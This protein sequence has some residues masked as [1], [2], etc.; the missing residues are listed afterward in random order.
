M[1][2]KILGL[3]LEVEGVAAG[4]AELNSFS[5]SIDKLGI[6]SDKTGKQLN[7]T[8]QAT[9]KTEQ[10]LEAV[11]SAATKAGDKMD[12]AGKQAKQGEQG[13]K[14]I[15]EAAKDAAAKLDGARIYAQN[16]ATRIDSL[17][18][19]IEPG[20]AS[21]SKLASGTVTLRQAFEAG[22]LSQEVY[23]KNLVNLKQHVD[24]MDK[25]TKNLGNTSNIASGMVS[26]LGFAL[27][28]IFSITG[29]ARVTDEYTRFTGQLKLA[30][31]STEEYAQAN[32]NTLAIARRAQTEV[33]STGIL[34]ARLN[35][36]LRGLNATQVEVSNIS[37]TVALSLRVSGATAT[38]SASAMLQ[39]SQAF[40]SGVL[41]GEEFN[42][43]N[44]AAPGL[45][46]TL[47]EAIN[48]PV[49][50]LREMASQGLLTSDILA[51]AFNNPKA[52]AALRQQAKEMQTLGS[53]WQVL[54][55]S[56]TQRIGR[57]DQVTGS[58]KAVAAAMLMVADNLGIVAI[59]GSAAGAG[60]A[61][62]YAPTILTGI[63]TLGAGLKALSL[64]LLGPVGLVIG[65]TAAAG[66]FIL[67]R[68]KAVPAL[69]QVIAKQKELNKAKQVDPNAKQ[70]D[71]YL[72]QKSSLQDLIKTQNELINR[73]NS[74]AGGDYQ[75]T[76][77][78]GLAKSL[79]KIDQSK[80][81]DLNQKI[82]ITS[83]MIK[84]AGIELAKLELQDPNRK[85]DPTAKRFADLTSEL[86]TVIDVTKEYQ[87]QVKSITEAANREGIAQDVL[88]A[89]L[90]VLADKYNKATGQK[91]LATEAAN[92]IANSYESIVNKSKDLVT[93]LQYEIDAGNKL[94]QGQKAVLDIR[95]LLATG[96]G[97]LS[98]SQ[99]ELLET[100][101]QQ[102][103]TLE[104]LSLAE[105]N[106]AEKMAV[107]A[108]AQRIRLEEERAYNASLEAAGKSVDSLVASAVKEAQAI[109]QQID[110]LKLGALAVSNMEQARLL[111][112]AAAY[113]QAA[114]MMALDEY[115]PTAIKFAQEQA[116]SLRELAEA[117]KQ[118]YSKQASLDGIKQ[119]RKA[120]EDLVTQAKR[121]HDII[122]RSL[123]DALLRGFESGKTFAENLRDTIKNM[124][125]T[126]IL[127]PVIQAV[128][129]PVSN[130]LSGIFSGAG[131]TNGVATAG[132]NSATNS[133]MGAAQSIYSLKSGNSMSQNLMGTVGGW[134]GN[135][136]SMLGSQT[137]SQFASG[138]SG[139]MVGAASGMGATV[140]GS[141]TGIG[142]MSSGWG[143]AGAMAAK[144]MPWVGAAIQAL[145]GDVRGAAFTAAGAAIGSIIPGIGT[146]I[147]AVIGS[148]I[149]SLTGGKKL[150]KYGTSTSGVYEGGAYSNGSI[151]KLGDRDLGVGSALGGLNEAFSSS[152]GSMLSAFGL[153]DRIA[154]SSNMISRTNVR[155]GFDASFEGGSVSF[156]QNFGK[157]KRTTA[158]QAFQQMFEIVMGKT[159]VE[160]IQRSK[161][162]EGIRA[163]FNGLTDRT[164]VSE[165][166]Q[167]SLN[168]NYAQEKLADRFGLTVDAAAKVAVQSGYT[169]DELSK[170]VND[171]ATTAN[172]FKT[173]SQVLLET[174][175]TLLD[176]I[177]AFSGATTMPT[178]LDAFDSL[179][180]SID[181][182]TQEGIE[183]FTALFGI[184]TGFTEFTKAIDTLKAN[185]D[186]S[187]VSMLTPAE[188]LKRLESDLKG[189]FDELNLTMPTSIDELIKLGTGIDYT[190]EAGLDL[191]A[192]FPSL[193]QAFMSLKD[194]TD[195][196]YASMNA[197][198]TDKF[199]SLFDLQAYKG[200]ATNSGI[201][202]ANELLGIPGFASGGHHAGGW[203]I[204]GEQG[205]ELEYTGPS[206]IFN[207]QQTAQMLN[208]GHDA[209]IRRLERQQE[210][211][212][213]VLIQILKATGKT[214]DQLEE[215]DD[216]GMPQVQEEEL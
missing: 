136:G 206:Q 67:M 172:S 12:A 36:S 63:A 98:K 97:H 201:N 81:D 152:L 2:Q 191:A 178:T 124:F 87:E 166:I 145:S 53:G 41:R 40:G 91:K 169:G 213:L 39:L 94:T 31:R 48:V 23:D 85:I 205:P 18:Q 129:S 155:G 52:L 84:G 62:M 207:N 163:L 184:R 59:A 42:A 203:R 194:G 156:G 190:T 175:S 10:A 32:A 209:D 174:K 197:F 17:R 51:N 111:D 92:K 141:A 54:T 113:E 79:S 160:A 132:G 108:E 186:A 47:A 159:L 162:P 120:Q 137:L 30:T 148:L 151:G 134:V 185:V 107:F 76:M 56:I 38:E 214:A 33:N 1:T 173:S 16:L 144:A 167:A 189:S 139:Q 78:E 46:R 22:I 103:T 3:K 13:I 210:E 29:L 196:L 202:K 216:I 128:M 180:K 142:A 157:S 154:S 5:A 158:E 61:A 199:A 179:L 49:G 123:T 75:G 122:N 20:Y 96:T 127:R 60:L 211:I 198:D 68:D 93:S 192:A 74:F 25:S 19:T 176:Y 50:S 102:I 109:Q 77:F 71:P 86:K 9:V 138:M 193:V 83:E 143:A 80:I 164:K 165:M 106:K 45:M 187:V 130:M 21:M 89:K 146:A 182:T 133:I 125:S 177:E 114:A 153:N 35:N 24:D 7:T 121:D 99:R 161:L 15:G 116:R 82:R 149:G 34:Y 88:Q 14:S 6:N 112:A 90:A 110:V 66:A 200:I 70:D 119:V 171:L 11:G 204:V 104:A 212:K 28:A 69:D 188:Q 58:S 64:S 65:L 135:I 73:R 57:F 147:G 126:L 168:L 55:D 95:E 215:W 101:A 26:K 4:A 117:R 170:F 100:Y 43:V 195:Q 8:V 183:K 208:G 131:T 37:E 150:K 105:S 181:T 44:E 115:S 72:A 27:G 118:A 140:A